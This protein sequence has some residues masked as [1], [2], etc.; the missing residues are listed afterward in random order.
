MTDLALD[1]ISRDLILKAGSPV[2]HA[3]PAEVAQSVGI[4]LR[5]FLGDWFLDTTHGVPYRES[6]LGKVPRPEI[7][8]ALL[9]AQILDVRGIVGIEA[10]DL[11]IDKPTRRADVRFTART[12][13]GIAVTVRVTLAAPVA[14]YDPANGRPAPLGDFVLAR[15]ILSP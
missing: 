14:G 4:R 2:A 8:E 9:R 13:A 15:N 3:G 5:A 1:P 7:V 10:F 12:T 6:I 11:T